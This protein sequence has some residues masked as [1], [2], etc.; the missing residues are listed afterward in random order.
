MKNDNAI[1]FFPYIGD[2]GWIVPENN[3]LVRIGLL[4]DKSSNQLFKQML[5]DWNIKQ[6]DILDYQGGVVPIYDPKLPTQKD[7]IYLIG[8]A[9]LQVKATAYGGIIQSLEA[10][11]ATS[12]SILY[13][14]DYLKLCKKSLRKELWL[15]LQIRKVLD[16]FFSRRSW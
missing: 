12:Q 14:E 9:A 1:E 16:K 8:D 6:E 13:G 4:A 5:Q 7:N 15:H 2:I 11:K 3:E 10:A